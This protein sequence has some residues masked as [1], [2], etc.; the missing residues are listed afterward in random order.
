[1]FDGIEVGAVG[2]KICERMPGTD[3]GFLSVLSFVEGDIVHH[4]HTSWGK[5]GQE[6]LLDPGGENLRIDRDTEQCDRQ[7]TSAELFRSAPH[8][9][10]DG[11]EIS[12]A[13]IH[14]SFASCD[15][16]GRLRKPANCN[17]A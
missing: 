11:R 13:I 4:E 12:G 16:R 14:L 7:Q 6:V 5:L 15:G 10:V 8:E 17:S 3:D 1:M 2:G 9:Q